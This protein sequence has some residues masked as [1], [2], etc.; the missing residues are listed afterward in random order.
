MRRIGYA[1]AMFAASLAGLAVLSLVYGN[2]GPLMAPVPWPKALLFALGLVV[3]AASVGLLFRRTAGASAAAVAVCCA[4]W[5]AAGTPPIL[6]DPRS[7][8][9]WYGFSEAVSVLVGVW[10]LFAIHHRRDHAGMAAP[11]AGDAALRAG[12]ILFG[13]ACLVYGIAHFA[14]AAYSL[15][16]VPEWLPARMPLVY[17]TGIFHAAAGAAL[18]LG[19][20]PRLAARLEAIM[21]ILFGVLI[22]LPSHFAHP[23]PKWAG[24]PQNQWSETFVNF[25]LA[26]VAWLIAESLGAG[27]GRKK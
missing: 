9:S 2:F 20:L 24:T 10:T 5:A 19:V 27:A 6:H 23:T 16:F 11:L 14:Y 25:L 4:A 13:G 21:M 7:V 3:L 22:W 15:L 18:I 17:A 12:R 1:E 8:G 26:A